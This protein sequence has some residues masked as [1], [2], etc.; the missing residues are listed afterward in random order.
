[1]TFEAL[2]DCYV[3]VSACPQ[4]IT[5]INN[6]RP[7]EYVNPQRPHTDCLK[8]TQEAIPPPWSGRVPVVHPVTEP[9]RPG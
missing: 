2:M 7:T 3:V 8:W 9:E 4:D 6:A 5:Q 1:M